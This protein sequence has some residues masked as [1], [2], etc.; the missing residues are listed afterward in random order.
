MQ[1]RMTFSLDQSARLGEV[2][3]LVGQHLGT[4]ATAQRCRFWRFRGRMNGTY[5]PTV[6]VDDDAPPLGKCI[7]YLESLSSAFAALQC[8]QEP[9]HVYQNGGCRVHII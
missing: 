2:R 9:L 8:I 3:R 5:R 1:V 4:P 7:V 6:L